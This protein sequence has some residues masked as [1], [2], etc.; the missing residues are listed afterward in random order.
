MIADLFRH[1]H[2][3]YVQISEAESSRA[4][5]SVGQSD[6]ECMEAG[7]GRRRTTFKFYLTWARR[8]IIVKA[9]TM[10]LWS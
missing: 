6:A 8:I 5:V 2:D 7:G 10:L 4:A 3:S 9:V 1:D